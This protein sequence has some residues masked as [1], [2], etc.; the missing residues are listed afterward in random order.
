M[1]RRNKVATSFWISVKGKALLKEI[2]KKRG[3]SGA[4][5]IEMAIRDEAKKHNIKLGELESERTGED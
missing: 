1:Q 5:I 3:V 4:A 2:A